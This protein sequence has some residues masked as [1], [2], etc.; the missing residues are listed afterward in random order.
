MTSSQH[1]DDDFITGINIIP[2]VDIVLVLLIIFMVTATLM[3]P[4]SLPVHLPKAKTAESPTPA[5]LH[6]V[7]ME[8]GTITVNGQPATITELKRLFYQQAGRDPK[9]SIVI[10]ADRKV[11]HGEVIHLIDMAREAGLSRF[12][13][14]VEGVRPLRKDETP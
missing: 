6:V 12:A 5:P 14:M 9:T 2:L 13:F 3:Q 7:L 1:H 11:A 4:S 8:D 10:G